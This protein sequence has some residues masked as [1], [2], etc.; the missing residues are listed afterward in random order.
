M[1]QLL[2]QQGLPFPPSLA[3]TR[4]A[5]ELQ[6]CCAVLAAL[7]ILLVMALVVGGLNPGRDDLAWFMRLR[8][9]RWLV[10]EGWIPAIWLVIYGCFC[11]SAWL[12]WQSSSSG[13]L[14]VGYLV[15]LMLVQSYTLLI[16]RSRS[17]GNGTLI[18]FVGWMWGVA[19]TMAVV[20][21]NPAAAALL[22]PYLI[23]SPVGTWVTWQM[24]Q[25]NR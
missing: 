5:G 3:A 17:L 11:V 24:R 23:W 6:A 19:L 14:M 9:P 2:I 8:R 10:F 1:A 21:Q 4:Q 12:A 20:V 25:L 22:A 13:L 7:V 15:Q 18:G 16:C